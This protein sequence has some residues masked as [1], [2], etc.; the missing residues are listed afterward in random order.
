MDT[1]DGIYPDYAVWQMDKTG[2]K[3]M[4]KQIEMN[5]SPPGQN[6]CHFTDDNFRCIFVNENFFLIKISLKFVP[7]GPIDNDPALVKIMAWRRIGDKLLSEPL[8][9]RFTDAYMRH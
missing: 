2:I 9:T 6:G 8:L 3:H 1:V 4:D 7:K 5:S